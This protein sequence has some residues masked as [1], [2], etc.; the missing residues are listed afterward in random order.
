MLNP[1]FTTH[2]LNE[3]GIKEAREVGQTFNQCL[4]HLE[5]L[6]GGNGKLTRE[7]SL[8]KTKLEEAC[9]FAKKTLASLPENQVT[10]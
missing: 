2:L 1:L 4:A 7:F 3:K 10:E 8:V 6:V 9:F 5:D